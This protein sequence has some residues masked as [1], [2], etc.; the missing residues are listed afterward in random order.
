[1]HVPGNASVRG[2]FFHLAGSLP[3]APDAADGGGI[4]GREHY[5]RGR[6]RLREQSALAQRR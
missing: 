6:W 1:M 3:G 4:T 2:V 5:F